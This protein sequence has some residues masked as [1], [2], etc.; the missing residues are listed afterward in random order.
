[1][2]RLLIVF[3]LAL[4]AML[5][6][7]GGCWYQL[8]KGITIPSLTLPSVRISRLSVR[9]EHRLAVNIDE[10]TIARGRIAFD[11]ETWI[12]RIRTA[13]HLL[14]DLHIRR[15]R[16][17]GYSGSLAWTDR[18][19]HL[20]NDLLEL[21][22]TLAFRDGVFAFDLE[23]LRTRNYDLLVS[24][25]GTYGF[26]SRRLAFAGTVQGY[27]I[28]GN[29]ELDLQGEEGLLRLRTGDFSTLADALAPFPLEPELRSWLTKKITARAMR[30]EELRCRF[31]LDRGVPV[32][33][34]QSIS[35]RARLRGVAITFNPDL[36]PVRVEEALLRWHDDLLDCTLTRPFYRNRSLAGSHVT[37]T[38]LLGDNPS[39]VDIRL[40]TR[41]RLDQPVLDLLH[42]YDIDLPLVQTDGFTAADLRLVLRL[43]DMDVQA[44]GDFSTG[45]SG[46]LWQGIPVRCEAAEVG[47]VNSRITIRKAEL[48]WQDNLRAGLSG[49]VDMAAREA[50][51][52][53][54]IHSLLL[55]KGNMT[56]L[57]A[58]DLTQPVVV[59]FRDLTTIRLPLLETEIV[60]DGGAA[61]V[62]IHSL[63]AV[64][65]LVPLLEE[66]PLDD[67][68]LQVTTPDMRRFRF[69]GALTLLTSS[70][71][72]HGRPVTDF[73][74]RGSSGPDG[75]IVS[76]N[77]GK[78]TARITE[79]LRIHLKDYGVVI[80]A[81]SG[82]TSLH[83]ALPTHI[84]AVNSSLRIR[85]FTIAATSYKADIDGAMVRFSAS[86]SPS[87]TIRA[88]RR[89]K[90]F[91]LVGTGL[92][93]DLVRQVISFVDLEGGRFNVSLW[94]TEEDFEG[95][96]E[97]RNV[98]VRD[99]EFVLLNN[100]MAFL[101]T[102]PALA[103]F[104]S[105]GFNSNGYQVQKGV[106]HFRYQ[107]GVLT[108]IDSFSEG[109]SINTRAKGSLDFNRKTINM[110]VTLQT[111]KS[112][113][114]V[115]N[116]IPW[117]GYAILGKDGT[118]STV[119]QLTGS[120]Q[121]PEVTTH[122]SEQAM[123]APLNILER[124]LTWPFRLFGWD[125]DRKGKAGK[126]GKAGKPSPP[127]GAIPNSD[128]AED[129][130]NTP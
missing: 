11:P 124:T 74:F 45:R 110:E 53:A 26:R 83:L 75:T 105:A 80:G 94:G 52:S 35:G 22:A 117:V 40:R 64:R 106:V 46:W 76:A 125:N 43:R 2:R 77:K 70:L 55:G 81:D 59:D 8:R 67:G 30:I 49:D 114:K 7:A 56:L 58:E 36:A 5:L 3:S 84:S 99:K 97:C 62:T 18:T 85:G 86:L 103:T 95:Y 48:S 51:L 60:R 50:H 78:I 113:S 24:G 130:A 41:T 63:R 61:T 92:S 107:Q 10:L 118:M 13:S 47:L 123:L 71:R 91:H 96:L 57:R 20:K 33:D 42:A 104:S 27:G 112:L 88:E 15:F 116:T 121:H 37:V 29:V 98:L 100:I 23:R 128:K 122:L 101:D 21:T 25:S 54:D 73:R 65:P 9:L 38:N 72:D 69:Q 90:R 126:A 102:I 66:I 4:L 115:I 109:T 79:K 119:L 129:S 120:L 17:H 28:H 127:A 68:S 108:I 6:L 82:A 87:G 19:F 12:P 16:Y 14:Q 31:R 1:M 32:L 93:A 44:R 89:G 111:L 34:P 39:S